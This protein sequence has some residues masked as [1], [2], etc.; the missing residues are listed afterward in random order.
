M[1]LKFKF[2][3]KDEIPVDHLPL[4]GRPLLN[5]NLSLCENVLLKGALE[6]S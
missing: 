3:S 4:Y 2:K 1:S 5:G 6:R